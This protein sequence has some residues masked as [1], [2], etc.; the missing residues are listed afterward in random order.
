NTTVTNDIVPG[1]ITEDIP[2][3]LERICPEGIEYGH[4][5]RWQDGNG[6]SHVR[7][8]FLGPSLTIPVIDGRAALGTWQQIAFLELD[9]KPRHREVLVQIVG[10]GPDRTLQ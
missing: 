2:N 6:H 5:R 3:A 10:D 7:A 4:Q 9:N 1:L 8:T